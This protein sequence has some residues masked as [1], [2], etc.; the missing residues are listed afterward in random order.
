ML[1]KLLSF[2]IVTSL[3]VQAGCKSWSNT[4]K[5]G[6]SGAV[7]GA[8]AGGLLGKKSGN[9]VTGAIIGAAVGGV[10]GAAIGRYMDRQSTK[11]ERELGENAKVERIGE[12]I[13][14]TFESGIL[15]EV[16]KA[17]L[18]SIAKENLS[19]LAGTL[20]EFPD[21]FILVEGHTDSSGS[22]AYNQTLS[23]K[24]ARSVKDYI[25]GKN[26]SASRL[27]I[28]GYGESQP[29]ASNETAAGKRQNRRVEIAIY[30]NEELK[31]KAKDGK[32]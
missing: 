18:N 31:Q 17:E 16:S 28:K 2:L 32:I 6:T 30:A 19:K 3:F 10:A 14:V 5:G 21:T 25:S 20:Q 8:A 29:I 1:K 13:H 12:G 4:A 15:F 27:T 24:R 22:E 7:I 23:E 26:V 11:L 9:T